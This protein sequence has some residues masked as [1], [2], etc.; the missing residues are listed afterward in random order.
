MGLAD[1]DGCGLVHATFRKLAVRMKAPCER[2]MQLNLAL[3]F[4]AFS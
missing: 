1:H 4:L 2:Q 3:V